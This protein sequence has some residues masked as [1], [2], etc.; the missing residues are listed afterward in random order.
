MIRVGRIKNSQDRRHVDGFLPVV[1][2]T[3][4]SEYGSLGPYCLKDQKKRIMENIWQ[5]SKVYEKIPSSKQYYSQWDKTVMWD[6]PAE[7]HVKNGNIQPSYWSWRE[8]GMNNPYAVRYPVGQRYRGKCL[9]AI[10]E[11]DKLSSGYITSGYITLGYIEARKEIYLVIYQ[12]LVRKESQYKEL[13][14]L[15]R[16][17]KNILIMEVDGPREE[18]LPYYQEKYGV[19]FI[20]GTVLATNENLQIF[21]NDDRHPYGHGFCLAQTLLEDLQKK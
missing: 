16:S 14:Q 21:L 8:K 5:F 13:L 4:C 6:H 7:I 1:V 11:D 18:S 10:K 15:L 20:N 19:D 17:G 12:Q 3:K 2:M 9:Y